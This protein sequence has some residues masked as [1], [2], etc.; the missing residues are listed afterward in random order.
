[1]A[2]ISLKK[3]GTF[4]EKQNY[5][6]NLQHMTLVL[7]RQENGAFVAT[8]PQVP[9]LLTEGASLEEVLRKT[10]IAFSALGKFFQ[11]QQAARSR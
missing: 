2:A 3:R 7:E 6:S 9:E 8:S 1:M 11:G 10:S 5:L 4:M